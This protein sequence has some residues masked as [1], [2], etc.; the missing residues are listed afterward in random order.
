MPEVN[1]FTHWPRWFCIFIRRKKTILTGNV[2]EQRPVWITKTQR[3]AWI[4]KATRKLSVYKAFMVVTEWTKDWLQQR[5]LCSDILFRI[6]Y[7][8]TPGHSFI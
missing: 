7:Y 5:T 2:V 3:L 8:A 1:G 4:T 6:G